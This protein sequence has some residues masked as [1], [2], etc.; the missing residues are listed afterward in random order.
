MIYFDFSS[1]LLSIDSSFKSVPSSLLNS[2]IPSSPKLVSVNSSFSENQPTI[3]DNVKKDSQNSVASSPKRFTS[4]NSETLDKQINLSP[5]SATKKSDLTL[6]DMFEEDLCSRV[7][8][9]KERH[10]IGNGRTSPRS[11]P[12]V[13]LSDF[14]TDD[15]KERTSSVLASSMSHVAVEPLKDNHTKESYPSSVILSNL[16]GPPSESLAISSSVIGQIPDKNETRMEWSTNLPSTLQSMSPLTPTSNSLISLSP[17]NHVVPI[18][19]LQKEELV[20]SHS[21]PPSSSASKSTEMETT[22]SQMATPAVESPI[23]PR[24]TSNRKLPDI[25]KSSR[26]NAPVVGQITSPSA[27]EILFTDFGLGSPNVS[28]TVIDVQQFEHNF[29]KVPKAEIA[30][31]EPIAMQPKV[32]KDFPQ[33][34][35]ETTS[36]NSFQVTAS[37]DDVVSQNKFEIPSKAKTETF[38]LKLDKEIPEVETRR[39][40]LKREALELVTQVE[41][42]RKGIAKTTGDDSKDNLPSKDPKKLTVNV[43]K[44]PNKSEITQD[45]NRSPPSTDDSSVVLR[46]SRGRSQVSP[47]SELISDKA[48]VFS[49][50]SNISEISS[51]RQRRKE[52]AKTCIDP[53]VVFTKRKW[54]ISTRFGQTNFASPSEP[55][56]SQDVLKLSLLDEDTVIDFVSKANFALDKLSFTNHYSIHICIVE[57]EP[58]EKIGIRLQKGEKQELLVNIGV[59]LLSF[60]LIISSHSLCQLILGCI[61]R[62]E[63]SCTLWVLSEI[64]VSN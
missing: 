11:L 34:L 3:I 44:S 61:M 20:I 50:G 29:A 46:R 43:S 37:K 33:S 22:S 39:A 23:S 40:S 38:T 27:S 7:I 6:K 28:Q 49:S 58:S 1:L 41:S 47:R 25:F 51:S 31:S 56:S 16:F 18:E 57:K 42:S 13:D 4:W 53:H 63:S 14:S 30:S 8:L 60:I 54:C 55:E 2:E 5:S 59:I 62:A 10:S 12:L 64:T 19:L 45:T 15:S 9:T 35:I 36:T 52:I 26:T 17:E 32:S 21:M 24:I 48:L